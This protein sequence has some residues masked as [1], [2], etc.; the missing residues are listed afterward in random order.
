MDG[1]PTMCRRPNKYSK[2]DGQYF[3]HYIAFKK[4]SPKNANRQQKAWYLQI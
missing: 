2:K 1:Y 4:I 3:P